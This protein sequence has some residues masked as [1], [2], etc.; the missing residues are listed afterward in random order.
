MAV[1][2][3]TSKQ[4]A[5]RKAAQEAACKSEQDFYLLG[6]D[7]RYDNPKGWAWYKWQDRLKETSLEPKPHQQTK[8]S[9]KDKRVKSRYNNTR[10]N[11]VKTPGKPIAPAIYD[12]VTVGAD[13][14]DI[15]F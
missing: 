11:A 12:R 6:V 13:R 10:T 3:L 8:G 2:E 9:G 14:H 1:K 15:A 7:R 5:E 4:I